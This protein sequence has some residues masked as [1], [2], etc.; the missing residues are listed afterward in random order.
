M[1]QLIMI[2]KGGHS[3]VIRDII[4]AQGEY[5]L[6]GYLDNAIESYY[7]QDDLFFDNLTNIN[8][9]SSNHYFVIAIGNNHVR[10]K[11]ILEYGLSLEQFATLIHPSAIISPFSSVGRG[12]VVMPLVV[13]N[14]NTRIGNHAI[15]NSGAVV[16][17]DN[18]IEDYVHISPGALL[19]G[20][21]KVGKLAHVAI[22][23]N[24]LPQV[25]IG[26]NSIV[27]AGA[28]VIEDVPSEQ[29]VIGTPA[30]PKE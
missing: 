20:G 13:I 7:E 5:Q 17:H 10:E 9:Y 8:K 2:G 1:K 29:T 16:E 22:G 19:A 23:S 12:T 3:K 11:I 15:V 21:V 28:T 26:S 25:K 24:V 18:V 27:G 30:K 14:A 4:L 6:V